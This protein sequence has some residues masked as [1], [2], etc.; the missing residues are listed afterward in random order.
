MKLLWD[1][2]Q[3]SRGN[4]VLLDLTKGSFEMGFESLGFNCVAPKRTKTIYS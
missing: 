3:K 2:D 4:T 1:F